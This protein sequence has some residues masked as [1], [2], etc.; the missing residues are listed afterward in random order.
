MLIKLADDSMIVE[1]IRA[2]S[3]PPGS[4]TAILFVVHGFPRE[5]HAKLLVR[6]QFKLTV[7]TRPAWRNLNHPVKSQETGFLPRF[8]WIVLG[9]EGH[10]ARMTHGD[11]VF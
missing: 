10:A 1:L 3:T 9:V 8:W 7:K 11:R 4:P 6:S 5:S 2:L